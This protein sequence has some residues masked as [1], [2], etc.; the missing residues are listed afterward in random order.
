M[1]AGHQPLQDAAAP[2]AEAP[3]MEAV[4]SAESLSR[5][6]EPTARTAGPSAANLSSTAGPSAANLSSTAGPSAVH[7]HVTRPVVTALDR[8]DARAVLD[9]G[10][11]NGWFTEALAR[12]GFET[13][14]VDINEPAIALARRSHP[15][16]PFLP[17]DATQTPPAE[18]A[19]RFDAVVA[20][21]VVDHVAQPRRLLHQAAA[22]LR[23][24]GLLLVTVPYHGYWKNLG[25]ALSG[26]FDLRWQALEDSGR[27]KFYSPPTLA[28]LLRDSGFGQVGI[29]RVGR[30]PAL[31][32]SM[33]AV[34][35][36]GVNGTLGGLAGG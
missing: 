11:G 35:V 19:G 17:F 34:G 15:G 22:C 16:I 26:R 8:F 36:K 21:D 25:V 33:V 1:R 12:C 4:P 14:G 9:L 27:L 10:C 7:G 13:L 30:I 31:A 5:T 32:R 28:A 20:I 29:E 2:R 23:P 6:A 24:G 18:L 3:Q